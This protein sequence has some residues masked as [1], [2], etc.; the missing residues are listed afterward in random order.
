VLNVIRLGL[1]DQLRRSLG[2]TNVVERLT[3]VLRQVCRN[4]TLPDKLWPRSTLPM[5]PCRTNFNKH[6][7][8]SGAVCRRI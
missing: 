2:C 8:L 1:P 7:G 3:A 6:R 4:V 5:A